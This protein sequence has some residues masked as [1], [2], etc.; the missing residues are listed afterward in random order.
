M[1]TP[2]GGLDGRLTVN[3]PNSRIRRRPLLNGQHDG[4]I[5]AAGV[6]VTNTKAEFCCLVS[7][8]T[9]PSS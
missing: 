4:V 1:I 2:G 8:P 9:P 7:K 3:R 5:P 6:G